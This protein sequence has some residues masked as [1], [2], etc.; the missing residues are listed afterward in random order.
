MREINKILC[1]VVNNASDN[2]K[3][4]ILEDIK[5]N[6]DPNLLIRDIA[7]LISTKQI[8]D[9]IYQIEE[10]EEDYKNESDYDIVFDVKC[11]VDELQQYF[12]RHFHEEHNAAFDYHFGGYNALYNLNKELKPIMRKLFS[13]RHQKE[14]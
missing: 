1:K 12:W 11:S 3:Q 14:F 8:L 4:K 9:V 13:A 2:Y 6:I 10:D 5:F 7:G